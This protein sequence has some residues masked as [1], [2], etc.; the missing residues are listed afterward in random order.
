M[1]V[2]NFAYSFMM[3]VSFMDHWRLQVDVFS[4]DVAWGMVDCSLEI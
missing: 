4:L 3:S 1:E 2:A